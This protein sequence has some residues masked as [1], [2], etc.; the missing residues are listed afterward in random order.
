MQT[1]IERSV[2]AMGVAAEE[3]TTLREQVAASEATRKQLS[4]ELTK[5]R[6]AR[7]E[8]SDSRGGSMFIKQMQRRVEAEAKENAAGDR[9]LRPLA[10]L[11]PPPVLRFLP[12]LSLPRPPWN[13]AR[14]S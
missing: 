2:Q 12:A 5:L 6:N 9:A 10:F 7:G 13:R 11:P 8:V 4:A 1:E 14:R 3:V